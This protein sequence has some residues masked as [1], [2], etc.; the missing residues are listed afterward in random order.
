MKKSF[1]ACVLALAMLLPSAQALAWNHKGHMAVAFVAYQQL[2]AQEKTKVFKLLKSHPDFPMLSKLAGRPTSSNFRMLVF[3]HAARWPDLIRS[4]SRF[5]DETKP[6]ATPTRQLAGFP[7]MMKHRPW[8]FK[9]EG[10]RDNGSSVT[11]PDDGGQNA[12]AKIHDFEQRIGTASGESAA[13]R[14]YFL[15]WLEHLVGD[16]HQPLHCAARVTSSFPEG[17]HGGNLF[18]LAP[19]HLQ[20]V[21]FVV[22]DLHTLWDDVIG[23]DTTLVA[24]RALGNEAEASTPTESANDL[25]EADWINE[26]FSD[27]KSAAYKPLTDQHATAP[28]VGPQYIADART[29]ALGR[30]KLAGHRLAAVIKANL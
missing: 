11:L 7:D 15:A 21:G 14:A 1:A 3:V 29:L 18:V 17:D 9:D 13:H 25:D 2:T 12:Q 26:S 4:D 24:V 22:K 28:Q 5:F 16:V 27:A 30:I 8:H 19:L 6:N 20:E 23:A 10:F